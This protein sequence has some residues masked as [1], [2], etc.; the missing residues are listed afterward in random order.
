[1]AAELFL[2]IEGGATR[3]TGVLADEYMR[4]VAEHVAG[5]TNVHAVG[6]AAAREAAMEVAGALRRQ[7]GE[8]WGGVAA[9]AFCI[10]GLRGPADR[11]VWEPIAARAA[12]PGPVLLTH[13]AAAGLAAGSEDET[14]VL[15]VCGT[16]SLVYGR[17]ADGRERFVGGRGPALGDGGSGFDIGLRALRAAVRASDGRGPSTLLE[18]LIPERIGLASVDDLVAWI[19][20][21][22]K[23]RIAGVAPIAFEAA[24]AGDAVARRIIES[25]ADELARCITIVARELWPSGAGRGGPAS[26]V[27]SGGVLREQAGFRELIASSLRESVPGASCVVPQVSGAVG[28]ARVARRWH[29]AQ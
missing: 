18:R 7:A 4:V 14:G 25:A 15:V 16:G 21:F 19:S 28:A 26:V 20:P 6:Q 17:T 1:M 24:S 9:S 27:L 11:A 5:P 3:T 10:A 23:D 8:A 2:G 12:A 13:D 22:A 29:R